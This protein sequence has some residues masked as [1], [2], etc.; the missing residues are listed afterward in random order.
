MFRVV[1]MVL[2]DAT[3]KILVLSVAKDW[4]LTALK[5][6]FICRGRKSHRAFSLLVDTQ[7][8]GLFAGKVVFVH[9]PLTSYLM[10]LAVDMLLYC[11]PP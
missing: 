1:V 7:M 6:R 11:L 4:C 2:F 8:S 9:T 5:A 3:V 10:G